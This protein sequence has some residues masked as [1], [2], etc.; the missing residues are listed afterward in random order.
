MYVYGMKSFIDKDISSTRGCKIENAKL[1]GFHFAV[2]F[3]GP[4]GFVHVSREKCRCVMIAIWENGLSGVRTNHL[5][6]SLMKPCSPGHGSAALLWQVAWVA[7]V[8]WS[9]SSCVHTAC[10]TPVCSMSP[11]PWGEQEIC[12]E[13]KTT[14]LLKELSE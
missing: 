14:L 7:A 10:V 3:T 8:S 2:R 12:P 11:E 1:Q 13:C 6:E 9:S 4:A 5:A